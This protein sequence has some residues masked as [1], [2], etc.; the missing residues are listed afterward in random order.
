MDWF[1]KVET[2]V[3]VWVLFQFV[4]DRFTVS[5]AL[6]PFTPL[7]SMASSRLAPMLSANSNSSDAFG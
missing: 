4:L 1:W 3:A 5:S 2:G 7:R 6:V